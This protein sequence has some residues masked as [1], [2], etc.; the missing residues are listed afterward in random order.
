M[1]LPELSLQAPAALYGDLSLATPHARVD[2]IAAL[3]RYAHQ[4][5]RLHRNVE[6]GF[7]YITITVF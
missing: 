1:A 6:S 7:L 2:L 5:G 4:K 3:R